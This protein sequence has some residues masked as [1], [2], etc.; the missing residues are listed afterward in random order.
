MYSDDTSGNKSKKWNKFELFCITLACLPKHEARKLNNIHYVTCSNQLSAIELSKPIV[1]DLQKL[2][3]G[4]E[5]YDAHLG[6]NVLVVAPLLCAMCD[7]VRSAEL[8]NHMGSKAVRLCRLC[9][10]CYNC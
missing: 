1:E 7:N 6:K 5:L 9:M 2:E 10:V 8:V 3:N 4:I